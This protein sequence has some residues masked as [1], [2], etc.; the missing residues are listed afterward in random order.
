MAA[1]TAS[2]WAPIK[3]IKMSCRKPGVVGLYSLSFPG[4]RPGR[5]GDLMDWGGL[6]A[7]G[8]VRTAPPYCP[9]S[10]ST[11]NEV[12]SGWLADGRTGLA[13]RSQSLMPLSVV[14]NTSG[15]AGEAGGGGMTSQ[16]QHSV[17]LRSQGLPCQ[18]TLAMAMRPF[19][20]LGAMLQT[21]NKC[22]L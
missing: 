7:G 4:F 8:G 9:I 19:H 10:D 20:Y 15:W 12:S 17:V 16:T 11:D 21:W 13:Y 22:A 6:G 5:G 14:L 18:G 1:L 3:M 2:S